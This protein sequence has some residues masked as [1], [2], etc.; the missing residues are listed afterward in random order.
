MNYEKFGICVTIAVV[1]C[2]CGFAGIASSDIDLNI[3]SENNNDI[4]KQYTSSTK[5]D[6]NA[7]YEYCYKFNIDNC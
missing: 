4:F 3:S 2:M 7:F 6:N 1:I 5:T